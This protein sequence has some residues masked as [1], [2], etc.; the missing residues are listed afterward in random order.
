MQPRPEN[1]TIFRE[2]AHEKHGTD[3]AGKAIFHHSKTRRGAGAVRAE[4][5]QGFY[6]KTDPDAAPTRSLLSASQN[7]RQPPLRDVRFGAI[8][9]HNF[10]GGVPLRL[11][12]IR[13]FSNP[14][15]LCTRKALHLAS[16]RELSINLMAL[17]SYPPVLP[18]RFA[19]VSVC[20]SCT[21][22]EED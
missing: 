17:D 19:S 7:R 11:L 14:Q 9:A 12:G 4:A 10:S 15:Q 21:G 13:I 6:P 5:G 18:V 16:F 20:C 2:A 22:A 8:T 1:E 3:T